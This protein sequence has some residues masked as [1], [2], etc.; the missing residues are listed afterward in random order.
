LWRKRKNLL[1]HSFSAAPPA[2]TQ[3]AMRIEKI[4]TPEAV[5]LKL[6][7]EIDLLASPALRD[8]LQACLA[9]KVP[10]LLLDFTDVEYIDSSGLSTLIEYLKEAGVYGGK[11]GLFGIQKKVFA[12]FEIVRL[13]QLFAIAADKAETLALL[14]KK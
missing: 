8:Q 4:S 2:F 13:D 1:F 14:A 11:I 5:V 12:V 10:V 9:D 6:D 7:G 3:E